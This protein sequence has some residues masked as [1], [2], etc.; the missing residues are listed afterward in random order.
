MTTTRA[1]ERS[2]PV[3]FM[4]NLQI[5][6]I[7]DLSQRSRA[8]IIPWRSGT[9]KTGGQARACRPAR[10]NEAGSPNLRFEPMQVGFCVVLVAPSV[11]LGTGIP[12]QSGQ[13]QS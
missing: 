5:G 1:A 10:R 8:L 13:D 11:G 7:T 3:A 6:A 9:A 4:T 2:R 12:W